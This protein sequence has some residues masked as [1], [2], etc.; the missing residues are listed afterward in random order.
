MKEQ[1]KSEYTIRKI[2][3]L[4]NNWI[5]N[6]EKFGTKTK[7]ELIQKFKTLMI[8]ATNKKISYNNSCKKEEFYLY[9]LQLAVIHMQVN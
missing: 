7:S 6:C 4:Q 5:K 9:D 1:R 8:C 2:W 3:K